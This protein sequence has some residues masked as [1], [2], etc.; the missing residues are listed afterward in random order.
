MISSENCSHFFTSDIF[1][2]ELPSDNIVGAALRYARNQYNFTTLS[3]CRSYIFGKFYGGFVQLAALYSVT[4]FTV[5]RRI[6]RWTKKK[7]SF[8]NRL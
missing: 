2:Y 4:D 6:S 3:R 5:S 8:L 7:R 1:N